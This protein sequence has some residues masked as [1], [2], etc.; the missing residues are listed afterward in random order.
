MTDTDAAAIL[1]HARYVAVDRREPTDARSWLDQG[2]SP[3]SRSSV[4]H[5]QVSDTDGAWS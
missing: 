4:C 2:E 3:A 1:A 5:R